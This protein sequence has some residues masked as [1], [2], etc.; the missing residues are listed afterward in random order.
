VRLHADAEEAETKKRCEVMRTQKWA[1]WYGG[2]CE[3]SWMWNMHRVDT[4]VNDDAN[5]QWRTAEDNEGMHVES[6]WK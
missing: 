2:W 1:L 5:I 6:K 4:V 3:C